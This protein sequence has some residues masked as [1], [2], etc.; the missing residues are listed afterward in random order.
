MEN[1]EL[2]KIAREILVTIPPEEKRELVAKS[3]WTC[4]SN[5]QM[6]MVMNAGWDV[7]NKMNL[8]VSQQV[9]KVEMLRLMKIL[10]LDKPRNEKEFMMLVAL[11]METFVTK[12]YFDY[13]FKSLGSGKWV[14]I[15]KQCYACTKVLS[16]NVDKDYECG[17]FGMRQGWYQAMGLQV[18]ENLV[19]CLKN[20]D[21]CCEIEI[22]DFILPE[23]SSQSFFEEKRMELLKRYEQ[24]NDN[25]K[26]CLFLQYPSLRDTFRESDLINTDTSK[27]D[28]PNEDI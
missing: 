15:V 10:D 6:A 21:D 28:F 24:A 26:M 12:D 25:D 4:D 22:E 7:A 19:K 17:C 11:A 14:G 8:Q 20:G 23:E 16:I 27:S 9:G 3:R 5:W 18:K 1:Q 13:E 2:K